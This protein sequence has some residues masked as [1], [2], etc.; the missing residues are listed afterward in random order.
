M[1][2]RKAKKEDFSEIFSLLLQLS[3][4]N[5]KGKTRLRKSYE[6]SLRLRDSYDIVAVEDK[7]TAGYASGGLCYAL[8]ARGYVF[9]IHELVI[10]KKHRRK[11]IAR[12]LVLALEKIARKR[13]ARQMFLATQKERKMALRLYSSLGYRKSKNIYLRKKL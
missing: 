2:I 5:K 3:P 1:R 8:W 11:G 12:E 10:A 13:K 6:E 4:K 7:E 9:W